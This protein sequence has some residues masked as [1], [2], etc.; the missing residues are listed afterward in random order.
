V[1][2]DLITTDSRTVISHLVS[3]LL[4]ALLALPLCFAA[5]CTSPDAT[6]EP[7]PPTATEAQA[8]TSGCDVL[9]PYAWENGGT[10]CGEGGSRR[11]LHLAVG[12]SATFCSTRIVGWGTGCVTITCNP[13]GAWTESAKTCR[14]SIG[15]SPL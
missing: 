6:D 14:P 12:Q 1:K 3:R 15:G 7:A 8:L 5:A 2:L 4:P 10:M 9:R 11:T 13:N